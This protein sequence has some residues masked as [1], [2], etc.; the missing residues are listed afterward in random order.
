MINFNIGQLTAG[1]LNKTHHNIY[2]FNPTCEFAIAN[3]SPNWQ[4]NSLLQKME[5]DLSAL[6]LFFSGKND[7]VMVD[8]M[9]STKL[10]ENLKQTGVEPPN[11][12]LKT[13]L[14][15]NR[16]FIQQPK[17]K[18]LPWGWSPAAHQLLFPLK[19]SCSSEFCQSPVFNWKP[20]HREITSRKFASEVLINVCNA[21]NAD[22]LLPEALYPKICITQTDFEN[23]V[24]QWGKIMVK[25][26]WSSSGRGLQPITKTPVH[27]KVWEKIMGIVKDQ[28]YAIAEPYLNKVLDRAFLFELK[29]GKVRFLGI[30]NFIANKKG[31]YEGNYINGLPVKT[32]KSIVE[33]ANIAERE[34]RGPLIKVIENSKMAVFYEGVFGVDTLIYTDETGKLKINPCLEINVRHTMGLLSLQL[35][36]LI[37]PA[38][39][40]MFKIFYQPGVSFYTFKKEMEKEYPLKISHSRIESGF[41]ALT[42][43]AEDTLFGA[44]L[45]V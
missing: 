30:S 6:P 42:E 45:L 44:Y 11:F 39:N 15:S 31:Q 21:T 14:N 12:I 25:A 26:P 10:I 2:L 28:G 17:N 16:Q 34:I 29:K 20:E 7:F 24:R 13:E 23:A 5:S 36:K 38:K 40:G 8:K 19:Q 9:P 3:G 33:F 1:K 41:L 37:K 35:E 4:P 32:N 22:Y 43:A 27:Q 18:L